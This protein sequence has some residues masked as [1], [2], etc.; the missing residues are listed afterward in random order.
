MVKPLI[1]AVLAR[2]AM[3][4]GEVK[5]AST[6]LLM[7]SQHPRQELHQYEAAYMSSL[8]EPC[9]EALFVTAWLLCQ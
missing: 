1:E 2:P 8:E 5:E 6:V 4:S 9:V 3:V 7:M